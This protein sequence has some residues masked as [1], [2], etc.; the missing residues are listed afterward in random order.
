MIFAIPAQSISVKQVSQLRKM[1]PE[2]TKVQSYRHTSCWGGGGSLVG[3]WVGG[4]SGARLSLGGLTFRPSMPRPLLQVRIA[5]NTL[6]RRAIEG[7]A[8]WSVVGDSLEASNMWFF[9]GS[10][11]KVRYFF[12]WRS[13]SYNHPC[14]LLPSSSVSLGVFTQPQPSPFSPIK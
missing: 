9:V 1:V 4:W 10:D 3:W 7:D 5:K 13:M 8:K 6:L 2:D 11:F 12:V 14:V